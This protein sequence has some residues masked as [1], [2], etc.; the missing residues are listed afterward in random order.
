M[1]LPL[2]STTFCLILM[3]SQC[4]SSSSLLQETNFLDQNPTAYEILGD[5]NLPKGLLP[6]GVVGYSLD[7][8]TGSYQLRYKSTIKGYISKGRLSR[9]EGVSVKLF[10]IWVDIIDVT[11]NGDDLEFSVGIAGADFSVDNFEVCPQCGCGLNCDG[12][13]RKDDFLVES[14][15]HGRVRIFSISYPLRIGDGT[16]MRVINMV[17]PMCHP[18]L[19]NSCLPYFFPWLMDLLSMISSECIRDRKWQPAKQG[20]GT[21]PW[22]DLSCQYSCLD[23][24]LPIELERKAEWSMRSASTSHVNFAEIISKNLSSE[25]LFLLR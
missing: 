10:F 8:T 2:I 18:S 20:S 9:L 22:I 3:L 24:L 7:T 6:K 15:G 4:L 5:Y 25:D 11:R 1:V 16:V 12:E 13:T 14:N 21:Q 23:S 19:V 17:L